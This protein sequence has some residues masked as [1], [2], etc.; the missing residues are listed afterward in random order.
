MA[1]AHSDRSRHGS[2]ATMVRRLGG[3]PALVW[4]I[5]L[6][7]LAATCSSAF[8]PLGSF[9]VAVNLVFAAIMLFLLATFLMNLAKASALLRLVA[10][11]GLFW[12]IFLFALT[13][14]DYFSRR[15]Y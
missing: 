1:D 14:A 6:V 4:L 12:V 11:A 3:G 15:P 13:F 9:N 10:T 2:T 7:L 8:L 5:L